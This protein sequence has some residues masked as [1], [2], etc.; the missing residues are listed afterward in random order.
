VTH[1][2]GCAGSWASV[3]VDVTPPP[4]PAA[5]QAIRTA[6]GMQLT[7][8]V[9]AGADVDAYTIY[10]CA[11]SCVG[12]TGSPLPQ[13]AATPQYL[14][15]SVTPERAYVYRVSARKL[16]T[17]SALSASDFA[18]GVHFSHDPIVAGVTPAKFVQ[19]TQMRMAVDGVRLA[20]GLPPG[21]FTGTPQSGLPIR[22]RHLL[23]LRDALN[24]ALRRLGYPDVVFS[25]PS[26]TPGSSRIR[27]SYFNQIMGGVQ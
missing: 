1:V 27:A 2:N 17:S 12:G 14:D 3:T 5:L 7:W 13:E 11:M 24:E 16:D 23:E 18:S 8:S 10:R 19:L 6:A 21:V 20:A 25:E 15:A 26:L 4:V 22:A 9:P